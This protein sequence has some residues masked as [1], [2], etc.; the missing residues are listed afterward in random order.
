MNQKDNFTKILA[1]FGTLFVIIPVLAPIVF[2]IIF[3]ISRG[4]FRIDY[5][6]PAELFPAV[7]IGS[8]LLIWAAVRARARRGLII[9]SF[10]VGIVLLFGGQLLAVATG[11]ASGATEPTGFWWAFTL[12]TI[13][14]FDLAVA[15]TSIG[16]ILLTIDLFKRSMPQAA[17]Q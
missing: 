4:L 5:L 17:S 9:A 6:M 15:A 13:I 10:A 7:L 16:G 11:L 8:G 2:S 3:L 1:V 14:A 12:G